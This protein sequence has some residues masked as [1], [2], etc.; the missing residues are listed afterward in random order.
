MGILNDTDKVKAFYNNVENLD[1]EFRKNESKIKG[2]RAFNN[3]IKCAI[4]HKFARLNEIR[5]NSGHVLEAGSSGALDS[6]L[7]VLEIGCGK[8]GDLH[9]WHK[10]PEKVAVYV[11]LDP[12]DVSIQ[13]ATERW[14]GYQET[15][16][17]GDTVSRAEFYAKDC[18]GETL[19]E[20]PIIQEVGFSS[21]SG[22]GFDIASMMFCMHYAFS[23]EKNIRM[24]LRN[25]TG[26]LK[27]GGRVI[28]CVPSSKVIGENIRK[29]EASVWR[30]ALGYPH[31]L[32]SWGNSIYNVRFEGKTPP[33][34]LFGRPFGD[35]YF[36]S[37]AEAVEAP[38]YVVPWELF[39][40]IAEEYGLELQ[41]CKPL[42]QVWEEEK[43]N[44]FLAAL[45]QEMG[46]VHADG[47]F[48]V[49]RHELEAAKFYQAFCFC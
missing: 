40:E 36:F 8:G 25:I 5:P 20:M 26:A 15:L 10:A 42:D 37:L 18:F 41:Y 11:G 31:D 29:L 27:P 22:G 1:A 49:S 46:V 32:I 48:L 45:S 4:I 17:Y 9:K 24:M 21:E 28:G 38:E 19:E 12:A 44:E 2:L 7:R 39:C 34:G 13:Q 30:S 23:D 3:W 35:R 6:G 33:D 43:N 14:E 16:K 47:T